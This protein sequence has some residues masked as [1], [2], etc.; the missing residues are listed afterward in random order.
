MITIEHL[1]K[2]FGMIQLSLEGRSLRIRP[3]KFN[4][5]KYFA[6]VREKGVEF[7]HTLDDEKAVK[8]FIVTF[9]ETGN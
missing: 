8:D 1:I 4:K 7:M 5:G 2:A 9:Y 3:N 6:T